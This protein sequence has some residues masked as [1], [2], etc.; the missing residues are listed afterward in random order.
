MYL[1]PPVLRCSRLLFFLARSAS[2]LQLTVVL[3]A[4]GVA[5]QSIDNVHIVP[6]PEPHRSAWG[7]PAAERLKIDVEMVLVPVTVTDTQNHPVV[8]LEESNFKL[9]EEN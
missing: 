1:C 9:F 3:L 8:D 4:A 5:A 7:I 6:R 2:G